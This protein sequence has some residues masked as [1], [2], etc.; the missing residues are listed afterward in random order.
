[1]D[2][3]AANFLVATLLGI[4]TVLAGCTSVNTFPR[5]ARAGDTI[6]VMVGGSDKARK[7]TVNASFTDASNRTW[8]LKS[9]GLVRSVFNLRADGR[10]YGTHY[11][12]YIDS[13]ISWLMGHEPV[14]TVLVAD[15]PA[16][17]TPGP[18][19]LTISLNASDNSSGVSDPFRVNLEIVSGTGIPDQLLRQDSSGSPVGVDFSRLETAPYAKIG[20]AN[21]STDI[22]AVS[23]TLSYNTAVLDPG[24]VNVYVPEAVV[25]DPN[26]APVMFGKTQRMVYWRQNGQHLYV[27]IVAPQGIKPRYLQVFVMHPHGLAATPDFQI[28]SASVYDVNGSLLSIQPNLVYFP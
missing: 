5:I 9:L 1:M 13:N 21:N 12:P 26:V 23:L 7:N 6:S 27:D 10:A 11:S 3:R 2:S 25:R 18:A 14:Q 17:A 15:I 24:D 22:G 16:S 4:A 19:F 8:D 28:M 20:F